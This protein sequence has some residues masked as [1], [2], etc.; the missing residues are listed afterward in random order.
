[1]KLFIWM[2]LFIGSTVGGLI[3]MLWGGGLL[4]LSSLLLSAVGGFVGIWA[5]YK[6]GKY[7]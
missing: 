2:G 5:G 1:M 7:I 3:P 4:S 6:L